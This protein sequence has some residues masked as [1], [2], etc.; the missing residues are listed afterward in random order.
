[1]KAKKRIVIEITGDF[2]FP[3]TSDTLSTDEVTL[4][5]TSAFITKA[6]I[7]IGNA[8][9]AGR[10]KGDEIQISMTADSADISFVPV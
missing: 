6:L 1:M 8:R 3:P 5:L 4:T 9:N 7:D 2:T 10:E